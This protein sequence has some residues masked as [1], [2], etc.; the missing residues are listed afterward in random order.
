[1]PD[2]IESLI[3][4]AISNSFYILYN[5]MCAIMRTHERE[6]FVPSSPF[7]GMPSRSLIIFS[8]RA[9]WVGK[10]CKDLKRFLKPPWLAAIFTRLSHE[11]NVCRFPFF[12]CSR[13]VGLVKYLGWPFRGKCACSIL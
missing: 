4:L 3:F 8:P 5:L 1:M 7:P 11:M 6:P 10:K 9:G 2:Y 12:I 13:R